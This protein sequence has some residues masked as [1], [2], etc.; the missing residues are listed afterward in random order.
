MAALPFPL[1]LPLRREG[2]R[3][4]GDVVRAGDIA[5]EG[6][7][8]SLDG[9]VVLDEVSAVAPA[10]SWLTVVGPNGAGKST[11]LRVIAGLV[12]V[13]HGT[14]RLGGT[15]LGSLPRR[16]RARR[17]AMVAQEPTM[18]ASMTVSAYVLLGRT[19]HLG[20]FHREGTADVAVVGSVL[21]RLGL[22]A[23]AE[24]LLGTLSGG[25]RQRVAIARALAQEA[26]VLLLDEPTSALDLG[27]QLD[28]LELVDELRRERGLTVVA[29]MHDLT[30]AG[31]YADRLVLLDGGRVAA[32]GAAEDVLTEDRLSQ[33][34]RA[35]VRVVHDRGVLVVVPSRDRAVPTVPTS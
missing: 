35:R 34:Y 20:L 31:Q 13:S 17:V 8:A 23:F 6:V 28:V 14:I 21:E 1:P 3:P 12:G 33:Y 26:P 24:R 22:D 29:T 19:A 15:P 10:G 4:V 18:P 16:E 27:H 25:E 9:R 11:L 5:V 30:L 7:R 2:A 32:S